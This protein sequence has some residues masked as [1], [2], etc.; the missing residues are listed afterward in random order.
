L[1]D[2]Y[3]VLW[4][5]SIPTLPV[6][7]ANRVSYHGGDTWR[8]ATI[9]SDAIT[10]LSGAFQDSVIKEILTSGIIQLQQRWLA[11]LMVTVTTDSEAD[12]ALTLMTTVVMDTTF[13]EGDVS[14]IKVVG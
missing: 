12:L 4:Q 10:C 11:T 3:N 13:L 2:F 6:V 9:I 14:V 7:R 8:S 5:L 1:S